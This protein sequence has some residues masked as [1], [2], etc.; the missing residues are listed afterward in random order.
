MAPVLTPACAL[1]LAL[2]AVDLAAEGLVVVKACAE[3]ELA[4]AWWTW[5][6]MRP[7]GG[8]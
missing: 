3:R 5:L 8:R 7:R 6:L 2:R 1:A 4:A